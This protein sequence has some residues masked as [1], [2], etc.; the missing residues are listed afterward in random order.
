MK[1]IDDIYG[2]F[3]IDGVLEELILSPPVQRLKGVYQG[4]ASYWVNEKWDVTRYEHSIGVMLLIR[5]LGGSLEEQIAG[6]LHDVSHTAFSHVIDFA[7]DHKNEDYHET[8]Y[9]RILTESDIPRILSGYGLDYKPILL[10]HSNWGLLER[11]APELCADRIDYTLRDMYR[12]GNIDKEEMDIFFERLTTKGGKIYVEDMHAAEWF[13]KI[14]YEEVIDFFMHPLNIYGYDLLA[15]TLRIAL[16]KKIITLN[17]LLGTDE[18]AMELL[19]VSGDAEVS[20]LIRRIHRNVIVKKNKAEYHVHLTT[21]VRLIDP[22]VLLNGR[23]ILSSE[24]SADIRTMND[25]AKRAVEEGVYVQVI[26]P[27]IVKI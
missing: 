8:I 26:S 21:K 15:K 24:L 4:G 18:E 13:V 2:E 20:D 12:Y 19:R 25:N 16:D 7:L 23:L 1:I 10:N 5:K 11:P 14:Y 17:S 22:S 6:L 27:Q 3:I 9:R